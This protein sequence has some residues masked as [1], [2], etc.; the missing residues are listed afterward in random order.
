MPHDGRRNRQF[1]GHTQAD[2]SEDSIDD[3]NHHHNL[4]DHSFRGGVPHMLLDPCMNPEALIGLSA[5]DQALHQQNQAAAMLMQQ[6]GL[7]LA[8]NTEKQWT[9]LLQQQKMKMGNQLRIFALDM[10]KIMT[11]SQKKL[12]EKKAKVYLDNCMKDQKRLQQLNMPGSQM[13][14]AKD[15]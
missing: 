6:M 14:D 1:A 12:L 5:E 15:A 7:G 4:H 10:F 8:Q 9:C 3:M 13:T 11:K 2:S